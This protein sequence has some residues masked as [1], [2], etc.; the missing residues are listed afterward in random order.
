MWRKSAG[1]TLVEN[2]ADAFDQTIKL[3]IHSYA[4][5]HDS[6]AVR[7][8]LSLG[9][10]LISE[11]AVELRTQ[12]TS[13]NALQRDVLATLQAKHDATELLLRAAR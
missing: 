1:D 9:Q 3:A 5:D 2:L 6:E 12:G 11:I 4:I 13:E 8:A 10:C 7:D